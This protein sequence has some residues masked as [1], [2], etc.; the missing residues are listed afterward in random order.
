MGTLLNR[1]GGVRA[2]PENAERLLAQKLPLAVFPEGLL[3]ISKPVSQRYKLQALRPRGFVKLALRTQVPLVP[4]AIV[5]ARRPRRCWPRSP[6]G[7]RWGCP[8]CR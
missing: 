6:W 8:T 1:L 3:G 2:C 5:G 7:C 4:V